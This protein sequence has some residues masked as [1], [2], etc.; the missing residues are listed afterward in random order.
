M[1][2]FPVLGGSKMAYEN[3]I[4]IENDQLIKKSY[5]AF[6]SGTI[7]N[8]GKDTPLPASDDIVVSNEYYVIDHIGPFPTIKFSEKSHEKIDE[9]M[10]RIV[11]VCLLGQSIGKAIVS[12][13]K[14]MYQPQVIVKVMEVDYNLLGGEH[15][16]FVGLTILVNL[17]KPLLPCTDID[18]FV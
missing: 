15:G 16:H 12:R 3:V 8:V 7:G 9:K 13:I 1:R 17:H 4:P 2:L 14:L 18:D 10:R 11:T 6:V 5:A